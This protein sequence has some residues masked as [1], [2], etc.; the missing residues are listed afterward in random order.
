VELATLP[1]PFTLQYELT[2]RQRLIPHLK[3][4]RSLAPSM[5]VGLVGPL[6][7]AVYWS[8]WLLVLLLVF[9]LLVRGFF[10]GLLDVLLVARK[11]MDLLVERRGLGFLAGEKRWFLMLDGLT[12]FDEL[13][14]GLWTLQHWNGAVIHI[15][16]SLLDEEQ[17]AF[18][19]G[20]VEEANA[21]RR[22]LGMG[23]S[24]SA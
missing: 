9:L 22:R 13:T 12:G 15:P 5:I 19:R 4:W 16:G 7:G 17:V 20:W 6:V 3:L 8:W 23:K 11:P 24:A 21:I 2:R 14:P 18:F 1:L 10:V